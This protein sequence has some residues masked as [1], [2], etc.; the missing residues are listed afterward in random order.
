MS[1]DG[2]PNNIGVPA[3]GGLSWGGLSWGGGARGARGGHPNRVLAGRLSGDD[4]G[5]MVSTTSREGRRRA[6]MLSLMIGQV[7]DALVEGVVVELREVFLLLGVV[8]RSR[9]DDKLL[10]RRMFL[11]GVVYSC[12]NEWLYVVM[13]Y[14]E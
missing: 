14:E 9:H 6:S 7:R 13:I 1:S 12:G 3:W 2:G 11:L 8:V 5:A 10:Q 4:S